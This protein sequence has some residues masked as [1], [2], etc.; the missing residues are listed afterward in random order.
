MQ[1]FL[2][3]HKIKIVLVYFFV[4]CNFRCKWNIEI[5]HQ[6][7]WIIKKRAMRKVDIKVSLEYMV[8]YATKSLREV[9][10]LI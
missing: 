9:N 4:I 6:I 2:V 10:L 5:R 7:F 8:G 3:M 1:I